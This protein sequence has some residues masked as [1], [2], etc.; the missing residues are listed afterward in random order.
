MI[1]RRLLLRFFS[2]FDVATENRKNLCL[3]TENVLAKIAGKNLRLNYDKS[4]NVT[5]YNPCN[6]PGL[7]ICKVLRLYLILQIV[8]GK[9]YIDKSLQTLES[10]RESRT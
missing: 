4:I 2:P 8:M 3:F 5:V 7:F 1:V 10:S 6:N 9:Q